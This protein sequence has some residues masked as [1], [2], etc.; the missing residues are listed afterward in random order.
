MLPGSK[1]PFDA[2][3]QPD[4]CLFPVILPFPQLQPDRI[5]QALPGLMSPVQQGVENRL[6]RKLLNPI[7]QVKYLQHCPVQPAAD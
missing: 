4:L 6:R 1:Q 3:V 7:L 5:V 2:I